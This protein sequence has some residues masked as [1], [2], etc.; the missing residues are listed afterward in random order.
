MGYKV[1]RFSTFGSSIKEWYQKLGNRLS[2][3][4][5]YQKM[6]E[7]EESPTSDDI[8]NSIVYKLFP[9]IDTEYTDGLRLSDLKRLKSSGILSRNI[10]LSNIK[11]VIT[12]D[13]KEMNL[14]LNEKDID[15]RVGLLSGIEDEETII[16]SVESKKGSRLRKEYPDFCW[17]VRINLK[18]GKSEIDSFFD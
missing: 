17:D 15:I 6:L 7:E 3:A 8:K 4:E 1:K 13:I 11:K 5:K 10:L 2:G 14:G 16:L 9:E 18:T 12:R